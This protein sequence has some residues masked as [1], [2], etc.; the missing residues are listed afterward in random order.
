[1]SGI[2]LSVCVC[3]WDKHAFSCSWQKSTKTSFTGLSSNFIPLLRP[4][5]SPSPFD[6]RKSQNNKTKFTFKWEEQVRGKEVD[7]Q[8]E[9]LRVPSWA[10][11]TPVG[12]S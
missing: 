1:M 2:I 4:P 5:A 8:T 12:Y 10:Q 11:L 3:V 9:R 6:Y 7:E